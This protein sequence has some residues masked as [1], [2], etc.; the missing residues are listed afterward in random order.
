MGTPRKIYCLYAGADAEHFKA[1]E[2]HV[3]AL[4]TQG[5]EF[6]HAGAVVPGTDVQQA[7]T[8][9]LKEAEVI[10]VFISRDFMGDDGCQEILKLALERQK[11]GGTQVLAVNLRPV[12]LDG[13]PVDDLERLPPNGRPITDVSWGSQ[14]EAWKS[15]VAKLSDLVGGAKGVE[16]ASRKVL[17]RWMTD[18]ST[19]CTGLVADTQK[20]ESYIPFE[21]GFWSCAFTF[22]PPRKVA[23]RDLKDVLNLLTSIGP[24]R[25]GLS[26]SA[27]S[28][29]FEGSIEG[30]RFSP[31][32]QFESD[33]WRVSPEGR[34]FF[35]EEHRDDLP[36]YAG[37]QRHLDVIHP[38]LNTARVLLY[39]EHLLLLLQEESPMAFHIQRGEAAPPSPLHFILSWTG[40]QGRILMDHNLGYGRGDRG[41][42]TCW[43][44][45]LSSER[46]VLG[47]QIQADLPKLVQEMTAPLFELFDVHDFPSSRIEDEVKALLR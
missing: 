13:T 21:K 2:N 32:G 11:Q 40:L 23:S 47:S 34:F 38:I 35:L 7:T 20:K 5:F 45:V 46:R 18:C 27:S 44:D 39:A 14:D 24:Y 30:F 42:G 1:F 6:L 33:Y 26:P 16:G 15:A 29:L 12:H 8:A 41:R 3:S 43:Q 31:P 4:K 25:G 22:V 28:H 10:L 36:A 19:R 9:A 37:A 17:G